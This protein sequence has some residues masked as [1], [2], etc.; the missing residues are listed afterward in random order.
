MIAELSWLVIHHQWSTANIEKKTNFD[1]E[2]KNLS[3]KPQTSATQKHQIFLW[4]SGTGLTIVTKQYWTVCSSFLWPGD[5]KHCVPAL[6]PCHW[7]PGDLSHWSS[8][9]S[10]SDRGQC[11]HHCHHHH[12]PHYHLSIITSRNV[13]SH[14]RHEILFWFSLIILKHPKIHWDIGKRIYYN[15]KGYSL[16]DM[17]HANALQAKFSERLMPSKYISFC[18][19]FKQTEEMCVW[20]CLLPLTQPDH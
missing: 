20:R 17:L 3:D 19:Y 11:Q 8:P 9:E 14:F 18:F 12:H 6:L 5:R 16:V 7:R 2:T 4:H 13:W 15:L 1:T 10:W